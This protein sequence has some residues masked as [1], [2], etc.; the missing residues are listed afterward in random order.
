MIK[1]LALLLGVTA[2]VVSAQPPARRATNIEA[3]LAHP[4]FYH[5]RPIIIVGTVS[6]QS[7]GE[8]KL[9]NDAGSVRVVFK[10]TAPDGLDEI[11]G[12]FWDI[13]RMK[14]DDPRLAGFDL[15]GTFHV[16]PRARGL[17]P[18]TSP[19]SRLPDAGVG[20]SRAIHPPSS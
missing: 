3:L 18:A 15:K 1:H 4:T 8:L 9:A 7:N 11:R 19:A 17:G 2:A 14:P 10:G 20:A 12:E 6:T 16:D 5:Q 13:G